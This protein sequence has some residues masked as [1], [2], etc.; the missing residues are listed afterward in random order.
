MKKYIVLLLLFIFFLPVNIGEN[1]EIARVDVLIFIKENE[2]YWSTV[3]LFQN[4]TALNASESSAKKLGISFNYFWTVYGAYVYE[5]GGKKA[6]DDYSWYWLLMIWNRDK[7]AWEE[8]S[9]GSSS[10]ILKDSS[11]IAWTPNYSAPPNPNPLTKY[12]WTQFRNGI[13]I[14]DSNGPIEPNLLWSK[15]IFNGLIDTSPVI[16]NGRVYFSTGGLYNWSSFKYDALPNVYSVSA[17][18]G[19]IIWNKSIDANGFN[20]A[21]SAVKNGKLFVGSTDAYLYAFNEENGELLWKF[22]TGASQTGITSSVAIDSNIYI[23]SGNGKVYSLKFDGTL[24]WFYETNATIYFS[25]PVIYESLL[26]IGNDN[27]TFYCLD[28]ENGEL[29]WKYHAS[30]RIRSSALIYEDKVYFTNAIYDGWIANDGYIFSL[31]IGGNLIWKKNIGP[32]VSSPTSINKKILVGTNEKV[33]CYKANG[34]KIWEFKP[35]GAV[36]SSIAVSKNYLYFA[37]NVENSAIYALDENGKE[38]WNY[39]PEPKN[40]ILSSPSISD[41]ILYIGS[42]NGYLYAIGSG[43]INVF[44]KMPKFS[45]VNEKIELS[46]KG[47]YDDLSPVK[48][49]DVTIKFG[50]K[51][52]F[53]KTD[54]MGLYSTNISIDIPSNYTF[55]VIIEKNGK[56]G[57]NLSTI[58][59]LQKSPNIFLESKFKKEVE[60]GKEVNLNVI[61]KNN[62]TLDA[63]TIVQFY[64]DEKLVDN[65]FIAVGINEE[66]EINFTFLP[67]VKNEKVLYLIRF[68]ADSANISDELTVFPVKSELYVDDIF[69]TKDKPKI[70]E[71]IE[72]V[73]K[74]K[75]VG[76]EVKN[77]TVRFYEGKKKIGDV[78]VDV[79]YN[80]TA[81]ASIKW[82]AKD[83]TI[84]VEV[85]PDNNIPE[86]N[87]NNNVKAKKF[88]FEKA[89]PGFLFFL[90]LIAFLIGVRKW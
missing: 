41:G 64:V 34:E 42:D 49:G 27:G 29:I 67:P 16:S 65:K 8:A 28:K 30:G 60:G 7:K 40:Y 26:F 6:P 82:V 4:Y 44:I 25:S 10:L 33:F 54:Y 31:D 61:V 24:N 3:F 81:I 62:G 19:S 23:A 43:E 89:I 77:V 80:Q 51:S 53:G 48:G 22:Y 86:Q 58:V 75:N 37:T 83:T 90:V 59:V 35:N 56:M 11:A 71:K 73:A 57:A 2:Y 52:I 13:G 70:G 5:I 76:G 12:P 63:N 17:K 88:G 15:N 39:T 68:S 72:I 66:K 47:S 32:S 38:I 55:L 1:N 74:I 45:Y 78:Y 85:D 79:P 9:V 20:I 87:E 84:K 50:E 36:Q 69:L 14:T 18:D 21:S 46:C